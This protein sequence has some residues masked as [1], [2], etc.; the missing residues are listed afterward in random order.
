MELNQNGATARARTRHNQLNRER[1]QGFYD[2]GTPGFADLNLTERKEE[3][4][5]VR[6]GMNREAA[7]MHGGGLGQ[8]C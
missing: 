2:H 7:R 5:D 1:L 8:I 3:D 4:A 6:R